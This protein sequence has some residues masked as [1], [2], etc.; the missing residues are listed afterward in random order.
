M[1]Q[2]G[3]MALLTLALVLCV[4]IVSAWGMLAGAL[5]FQ[6]YLSVWSPLMALAVGFWFGQQRPA[7]K[8]P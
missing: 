1:K 6:E 5:S 3:F 2:L 4:Q 7:E 8:S